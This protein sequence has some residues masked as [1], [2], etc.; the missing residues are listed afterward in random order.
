VRSKGSVP[1]ITDGQKIMK[2]PV[3]IEIAPKKLKIIV[4]KNR[5][6]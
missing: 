1:V 2:T 4:G 6:F 3:E 5:S